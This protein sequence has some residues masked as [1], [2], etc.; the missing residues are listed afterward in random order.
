MRNARKDAILTIITE[1]EI[2]TQEELVEKLA[3]AGFQVTQATVSRDIKDLQ[4]VK[5]AGKGRPSRYALPLRSSSDD[6]R[7]TNIFRDTVRSVDYSGN[8][9]VIKT[10]SGCANAAAEAL[11]SSPIEGILGTIAGDNT[12]FAVAKSVDRIPGMIAS[13]KELMR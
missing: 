7:F 10:L 1:N 2:S 9:I 13:L 12:V 11:D 6:T 8:I 3:E 5:T 4:L